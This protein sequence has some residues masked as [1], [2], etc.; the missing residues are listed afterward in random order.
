MILVDEWL[1]G[2]TTKSVILGSILS[3][4]PAKT[5]TSNLVL[6]DYLTGHYCQQYWSRLNTGEV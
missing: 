1:P 5:A 4:V 3:L 6:G 2:W